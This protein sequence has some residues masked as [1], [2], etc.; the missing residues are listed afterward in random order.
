[1]EHQLRHILGQER[2]WRTQG[3]AG[4][5]NQKHQDWK[6]DMS[7]GKHQVS[8]VSCW[9]LGIVYQIMDFDEYQRQVSGL[10]SGKGMPHKRANCT[11]VIQ[12]PSGD[13]GSYEFLDLY[14]QISD[15]S[16]TDPRKKSVEPKVLLM[17]KHA[18]DKV[19]PALPQLKVF[20]HHRWARWTSPTKTPRRPLPATTLQ[21]R[22][23]KDGLGSLACDG[24]FRFRWSVFR[25]ILV[26]HIIWVNIFTFSVSALELN[27]DT[28]IPEFSLFSGGETPAFSRPWRMEECKVCFGNGI[29]YLGCDPHHHHKD[30]E[31]K[32]WPISLSPKKPWFWERHSNDDTMTVAPRPL[33][34]SPPANG[35]SCGRPG[36]FDPGSQGII[37]SLMKSL[38]KEI[39][40]WNKRAG[41]VLSLFWLQV[42]IAQFTSCPKE[43]AGNLV[44]TEHEENQIEVLWCSSI[45][46]IPDNPAVVLR[47]LR[48][49]PRFCLCQGFLGGL[50]GFGPCGQYVPKLM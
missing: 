14:K 5:P 44:C 47:A 1:M 35:S 22:S 34:V 27:I 18:V 33:N 40:I 24:F 48:L 36:N 12:C 6:E 30:T 31:L 38:Q 43:I 26:V 8:S 39:L 7:F 29:W 19:C 37:V 11:T 13:V 21:P 45:R 32:L 17:K 28:L 25:K 16:Q 15:P 20:V 10:S 2:E 3:V 50:W 4:L 46:D 42:I 49:Y 41:P 23:C 9:I